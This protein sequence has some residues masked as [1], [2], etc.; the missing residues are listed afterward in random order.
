[1]GTSGMDLSKG[2]FKSGIHEDITHLTLTLT[3]SWEYSVIY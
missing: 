1:M 2:M 3:L